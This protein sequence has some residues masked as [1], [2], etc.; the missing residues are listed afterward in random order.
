MET[1]ENRESLK[2]K[3]A[4]DLLLTLKNKLMNLSSL[5][6]IVKDRQGKGDKAVF[7]NG[8][9]DLIHIGHLRYLEKARQLGDFLIIGLNSD[10][11]VYNLKGEGRPFISELERAELLSGLVFVDYIIIFSDDTPCKLIEHLKPDIHVKGGDY[12]KEDLPEGPLVESYGGKVV[13]VEQIPGKSSTF[14][15]E[16]IYRK[17]RR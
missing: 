9:F 15:A 16:E 14:L 3:R 4:S 17:L 2:E 5:P 12:K 8:C 7:T 6:P 13:V 1:W 10:T 11:S